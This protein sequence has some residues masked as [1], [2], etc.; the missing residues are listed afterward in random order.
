MLSL[1]EQDDRRMWILLLFFGGVILD[2]EH[3]KPVQ[4]RTFGCRSR[5]VVWI[6]MVMA[7]TVP[8]IRLI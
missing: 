5:C 7:M 4:V 6:R 8:P 2:F 3:G 1:A